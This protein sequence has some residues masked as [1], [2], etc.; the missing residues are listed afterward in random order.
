MSNVD[1]YFFGVLLGLVALIAFN[2]CDAKAHDAVPPEAMQVV[3]WDERN[4]GEA[5][6]GLDNA[7][8][9]CDEPCADVIETLWG[10]EEFK[11]RHRAVG[12]SGCTD[13]WSE[14]TRLPEPSLGMLLKVGLAGLVATRRRWR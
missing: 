1:R 5:R 13:G 10:D 7:R 2:T 3:E 14:Y 6:W 9:C 11:A 8:T 4:F 12:A